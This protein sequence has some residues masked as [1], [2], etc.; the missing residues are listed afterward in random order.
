M[1]ALQLF[2]FEG[3]EVRSTVIDDEPWF[4]ARDVS[5]ILGYRMA[6]DM[7]RRLDDDERGYA[8]TRTP[9]GE[10]E[11]TVINESG[12]YKAIFGSSVK[13]AKSF[14]RWVTHDVLPQIRQTGSYSVPQQ[15][16]A[17]EL[18]G[19]ELMA[20]A[21]IEA[22]DTIKAKDRELEEARPRAEAFDSFLS[23][24]GDYSV[25][26]AAKI[27]ARDHQIVTG[28]KRL[29]AQLEEWGWIYRQS[30]VPRAKQ[31]QIDCG[32]MAE[33]AQWHYH[34]ETGEKVADAPQVRV[35]AKGLQAIRGK[36]L[37]VAA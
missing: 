21:L 19:P 30:G 23:T 20:K 26:E 13:E 24:S 17:P 7:T 8:K 32:R 12:L 6:S 4:I 27:L 16:P 28:E 35:T 22:A 18:T 37:Q 34:P 14:Q 31:A 5:N 3:Q 33:K 2:A 9:S 25:N 29:R 11:M 36:W 1:S 10:Q 15:A